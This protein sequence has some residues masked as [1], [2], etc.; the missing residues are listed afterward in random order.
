MRRD[1]FVKYAWLVVAY[2]IFVIAFGVLVRATG[3]GAGCGS[4]WPTCNGSILPALER[5][6]TAIEFG[7]RV[8]S[9]FAGILVIGLVVWAF[10]RPANRMTRTHAILSLVFILI[11]GLIGAA[12][13]RLE[14]V[15]DNAST[16]RA[17]AI[18]V[19]L[20]N[21]LILLGVMGV[22]AWAA[23]KPVD[24]KPQVDGRTMALISIGLVGMLLLSAMGAVTALGDTLFPAETLSEGLQAKFDPTA[25][26]LVRLRI[27]HPALAVIV[28]IYL[29][30]VAPMLARQSHNKRVERLSTQLIVLIGIQMV[31][32]VVNVILLAPLWVQVVHLVLADLLW[33]TLII[34]SGELTVAEEFALEEE[35]VQ[36]AAY[37][38]TD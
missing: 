36:K 18:A 31:V 37:A 21:T 33:L 30:M 11:E 6:E 23:A 13:V 27:I 32:G 25:H 9:G 19:H 5:L 4:Y 22:T 29:V 3:S 38:G 1:N 14:L 8:T 20:V 26:F 7:H 34:F 35:F 12:L 24:F 15:E 28:S 10:R 17:I 2:T 16:L